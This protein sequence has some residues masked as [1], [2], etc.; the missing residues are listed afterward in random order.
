MDF[1]SFIDLCTS[2]LDYNLCERFCAK[3]G[4]QLS[5]REGFSLEDVVDGRN[6]LPIYVPYL[7]LFL[8]VQ[9]QLQP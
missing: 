9:L 7:G 8:K 4:L 3:A 5:R 6:S 2:L 1:H